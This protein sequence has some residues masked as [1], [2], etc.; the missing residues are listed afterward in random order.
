MLFNSQVFVLCFLPPV[1]AGWYLLAGTRAARQAWL[2]G[3]SLVFYG[4][5][6]V[7]YVPLRVGLTLA[8]WGIARAYGAGWGRALPAV[9]VTL[10]L[11]VLAL[12]K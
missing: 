12:F 10:N 11:L 7:R 1:L 5:W 4:W 2:V 3:A 9:G 8:N 6:D